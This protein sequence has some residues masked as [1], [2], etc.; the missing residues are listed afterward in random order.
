MGGGGCFDL[1]ALPAIL[2]PATIISS[3]STQNK[4]GGLGPPGP[5]PTSATGFHLSAL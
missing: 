2:S 3:I 4:G 1:L 5:S